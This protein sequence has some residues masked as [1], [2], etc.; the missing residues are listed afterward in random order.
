MSKKIKYIAF[1][2]LILSSF[3]F[4]GCIPPNDHVGKPAA[5]NYK[6]SYYNDGYYG[7]SYGGYYYR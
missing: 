3:V 5:H 6:D 4:T 2:L 7:G 1:S